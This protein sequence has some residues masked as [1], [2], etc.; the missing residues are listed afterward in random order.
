MDHRAW[1]SSLAPVKHD[2]EGACPALLPGGVGAALTTLQGGALWC[3]GARLGR[4]Q[5]R[6]CFLYV[7]LQ[8]DEASQAQLWTAPWDGQRDRRLKHPHLLS[9]HSRNHVACAG[10]MCTRD[11]A[12]DY[13]DHSS[14][15][16]RPSVAHFLHF[17]KVLEVTNDD[18]TV[19]VSP[20]L[21]SSA[22][23]PQ[24]VRLCAVPLARRAAALC[25]A[26][27][28]LRERPGG[29]IAAPRKTC[30]AF[31]FVLS[32]QRG[33]LLLRGTDGDYGL[34]GGRRDVDER[35]AQTAARELFEETGIQVAG[36]LRRLNFDSAVGALLDGY[37][38]FHLV[39][40]D[41][42][43]PAKAP[44]LDGLFVP[45]DAGGDGAALRLSPEHAGY[46]WEP[47]LQRAELLLAF[48][49]A[50]LAL[51]HADLA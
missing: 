9:P 4:P 41:D 45:D 17:L 40:K 47:D 51:R 27:W 26:A 29:A 35:L 25:E 2:F 36:R 39:L 5:G 49:K 20:L 32:P 18:W 8:G 3:L 37:A 43:L 11:G 44:T 22:P 33:L 23:N 13:V 12:L 50:A 46:V 31:V 7:W 1:P 19:E 10:F 24:R 21:R 38:F 30:R 15:H 14:G 34:P 48:T 28:L 16:Y 6:S 42:D